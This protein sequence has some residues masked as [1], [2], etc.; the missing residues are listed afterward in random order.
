[1]L[2]GPSRHPQSIRGYFPP[3]S[4]VKTSHLT[5]LLVLWLVGIPHPALRTH[6]PRPALLPLGT[7]DRRWGPS[8]TGCREGRGGEMIC[9]MAG[10]GG[11]RVPALSCGKLPGGHHLS[12]L[13]SLPPARTSSEQNPWS[14]PADRSLHTSLAGIGPIMCSLLEQE[15]AETPRP[16]DTKVNTRVNALAQPLTLPVPCFP[17]LGNGAVGLAV[18]ERAYVHKNFQKIPGTEWKPSTH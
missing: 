2:A 15:E 7:W 8:G 9:P 10:K 17:H 12:S 5:I 3:I 14:P 11:R 4:S 16:R 6:T 13:R 1:M 18:T